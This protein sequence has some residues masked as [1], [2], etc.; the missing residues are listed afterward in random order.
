MKRLVALVA[1]A[2][3]AVGLYAATATGSQQ[4][5]TPAQFNALKKQVATLQKDVKAL[6]ANAACLAADGAASFGS[7]NGAAG[8][9]YKQPDGSE[10]LTS[11]LDLV[12]QG[13]APDLYIAEVDKTCVSAFR[14]AHAHGTS[15]RR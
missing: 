2:G 8:Y 7:D 12:A 6:K 1:T 10:I 14:F 3:A 11:A 9:H 13:E 5:V 15:G 4:A